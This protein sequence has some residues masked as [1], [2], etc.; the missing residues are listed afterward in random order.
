[1]KVTTQHATNLVQGEVE[2]VAMS[3]SQRGIAAAINHFRD[4]TYTFKEWAVVREIIANAVDEHNK[5]GIQRPVTV[6]L[7][8]AEDPHF[9]VR[10]YALGLPKEKV[11]GVF[12]QYFESTKDQ[13]ND[14]IG[15]F[16]IGAK[17]PLAYATM[18][19]VDSYHNGQKIN[20]IANLNGEVSTAHK[21]DWQETNETGIEVSVPVEERDFSRFAQY[22]SFLLSFNDWNVRVVGAMPEHKANWQIESKLGHVGTPNIPFKSTSSVYVRIKGIIY[23]VDR[24]DEIINPFFNTVLLDFAGEDEI[25]LPPSRERIELTKRN[26]FKIN[27]A[28]Q[29]LRAEIVNGLKKQVSS[30]KSASELFKIKTNTSCLRNKRDL[31]LFLPE[32]LLAPACS[33]FFFEEVER[34]PL[35]KFSRRNYKRSTIELAPNGPHRVPSW[36]E[37]EHLWEKQGKII[38]WPSDENVRVEYVRAFAQ[39]NN[40]GSNVFVVRVDTAPKSWVEGVDYWRYTK[41]CISQKE[42]KAVRDVISP[43]LGG[44]GRKKK[45]RPVGSTIMGYHGPNGASYNALRFDSAKAISTKIILIPRESPHGNSY[46]KV[47]FHAGLYAVFVFKSNIARWKNSGF[48]HELFDKKKYESLCQKII[49]KQAIPPN[50]NNILRKVAEHAAQKSKYLPSSA[51][52]DEVL[53]A[54]KNTCPLLKPQVPNGLAKKWEGVEVRYLSLPDIEKEA[55]TYVLTEVWKKPTNLKAFT[56][57]GE[58]AI[59]KVFA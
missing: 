47:L 38:L 6:T 51:A 18:F 31:C 15:G 39:K 53:T 17:S 37:N 7:P 48:D 1:M 35:T 10:D 26:I 28:L 25:K 19:F 29:N 41:N 50:V 12:F 45:E 8:T 33:S 42:A 57:M 20:Y 16:G 30:A 9:R 59:N 40:L 58:K 3:L 46:K 49:N 56:K 36:N 23:S 21:M 32:P 43:R 27:K 4:T 44:G 22:T 55:I 34:I 14:G 5:H 11:F 54:I 52:P 13:D 24:H 2:T